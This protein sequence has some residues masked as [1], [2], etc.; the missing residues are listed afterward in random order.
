MQAC[1]RPVQPDVE[2][3]IMAPPWPHLAQPLGVAL[4]PLSHRRR[5]IAAFTKM[6][7]TASS[8]A[9]ASITSVCAPVQLPLVQPVWPRPW[10]ATELLPFCRAQFQAVGRAQP[11]VSVQSDLVGTVAGYHRPAAGMADVPHV[12]PGPARGLG[13]TGQPFDKCDHVQMAPVAVAGKAHRLPA[14]PVSGSCAAP[15]RQ[16]AAYCRAEQAR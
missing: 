10:K 3:G 8:R 13:R 14:G 1:F 11:D 7:A 6:R 9:A 12:Q 15:A 5:L 4:W 2:M 16:P